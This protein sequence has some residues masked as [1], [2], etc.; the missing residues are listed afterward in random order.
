MSMQFEVVE[1]QKKKE[2]TNMKFTCTRENP[3]NTRTITRTS[4]TPTNNNPQSNKGDGFKSSRTR[5]LLDTLHR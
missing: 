1:N 3:V 4:A 2:T 5:I